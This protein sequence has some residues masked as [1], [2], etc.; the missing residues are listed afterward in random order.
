MVVKR[1]DCTFQQVNNKGADQTV[2]IR[3]QACAFDVR[4]HQSGFL[5][6]SPILISPSV[7]P[8]LK[9]HAR[10]PLK[11]IKAH[12]PGRHICNSTV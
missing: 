3:R 4:M 11:A 10:G 9:S 7:H 1:V 8:V 5:A 6:S 2:W 12:V